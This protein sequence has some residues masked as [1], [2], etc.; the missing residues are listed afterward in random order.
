VKVLKLFSVLLLTLG[1]WSFPALSIAATIEVSGGTAIGAT[2]SYY[3]REPELLKASSG[4]WFLVYARSQTA[5]SPGGNP[6]ILIYDIY[7][8]TSIDNGATW[9]ECD[10]SKRMTISGASFRQASVAEAGGKIWIISTDIMNAPYKIYAQ[11]SSDNGVTWSSPTVIYNPPDA[12]HGAFHVDGVADGNDIWLFFGNW[13]ESLGISYI[14]HHGSTNLWDT[15]PTSTLSPSYQMPRVIK[16]GSTFRMV[17][18]QWDKIYYSTT[19]DPASAIW[20]TVAIPG[21][22]APTG[23]AAS[24]PA[25]FKSTEGAIWVA[26]APWFSTDKQ[27]I[28]YLTSDDNGATWS[29]SMVFTAAE[30]GA[31]FWWDFRPYLSEDGADILFFISSERNYPNVTR[32]VGDILMYRFPKVYSGEAHYESIQ[33]AV[34]DAAAGST[35]NVAEGNYREQVYIDKS[36]NLLGNN[37]PIIEAPAPPLVTYAVPERTGVL[38]EPIIFA[39]GG[40]NDGSGNISG[41]GTINV[42]ISGFKVDG[43]NAGAVNRLTG[44]MVRNCP[45]S[46]ISYN[47]LYELLYNSGLP[48]T[49]GILVYGNS[50]VIVDHNTVNDW[51][52]GGIMVNGDD[53][54]LTDPIATISNNTVVGEGV[55]PQG[56]WAQNGI[57]IGFGAGGSIFG[58]EVSDIAIDDPAWSASGINLYSPA[59]GVTLSSNNVHNCQGSLNAYYCDNLILNDG[60]I[61]DQNDFSFFIGGNNILIEGNTYTANNQ[62]LYMAGVPGVTVKDNNFDGNQYAVIADSA[63]TNPRFLHNIIIGSTGAGAV[64]QPYNGYEPTDVVFHSNAISGNAFG[65]YNSTSSIIDASGNWWGDASGPSVVAPKPVA[66]R[67]QRPKL[68]SLLDGKISTSEPIHAAEQIESAEMIMSASAGAGDLVTTTV[69]YSPWW[70][71]NY[72]NDPHTNL[73]KWYLSDIHQSSLQEAVDAAADGDEIDVLDGLYQMPVNIENRSGLNILGQSHTN[74]I[75]EPIATLGWNVSTYGTSRQTAIRVVNSTGIAFKN[76]TLNFDNIKGNNVSGVLYWSSSGTLAN[77]TISNMNVPDAAGGYYE[78]TCYLRAEAPVF[79]DLNRAQVDILNNQFVKTGRLGIVAHDYVNVLVEG[80]NFDKVDNDFGYGIE[81]GSMATGTIRGNIF[82]KYD[83]WAATD[84]SAAAGIYVENSF[85]RGIGPL[86]KPVLI[87]NNEIY[88]CQY[89]L[90][91]GNQVTGASGAGDVDIVAT[92][93]NNNIH[94]NATTGSETSGGAVLVDEGRDYGSSVTVALTGNKIENI[95]DHGVYIYTTGN[96]DINTIMIDNQVAFNYSGIT[97]KNFGDFSGSVYNLTI[98]HNLFQN[99]FN[100]ENDAITNFWD[101]GISAGNCWSDYNSTHPG[102]PQYNIPGNG[103]SIDRYPNVDCGSYCDCKPGE[104]DGI[105]V[106]NIRDITYLISSLYKGG[107]APTPYAICSGDPN[108]SC[109]V[110]ISDITYLI[111]FLYKSGLPPASCAT[112]WSKCG[113]PIRK[114]TFSDRSLSGPETDAPAPVHTAE[115][116]R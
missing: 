100:A 46:T 24:D 90:Y 88:N 79:G 4:T 77:N 8:S 115:A 58:N 113:L 51:S 9:T 82:H 103:G 104:A 65:L 21:T 70:S 116:F 105:G 75:F 57:Q 35:V 85:T 20:S 80:N 26:C 61:F 98:H 10:A 50:N 89:G 102:Y 7:Y 22:D 106:I 78:L 5:Y 53:G 42:V 43:D 94:D 93:R 92:V 16:D 71:A 29:S 31:D 60:N 2:T 99:Y 6:D 47:D 25:I 40:T 14:K 96:G 45:A 44:I 69:D 63:C 112:W 56:N 101:D 74:T 12:A 107:P 95:E 48:Q 111:N 15:A 86:A 59:S 83:T 76:M 1:I 54:P 37:N 27:R 19:N 62:A 97:V 73:W 38:F 114:M 17:T 87:E 41:S 67:L 81:L 72:Y 64:I 23:G 49:F 32:G 52:R 55:L 28:E 84:H 33:T 30:Y 39:Y 36:L 13:S 110:N 66:G 68:A 108:A 18:T 3:E 34:N 109:N 11:F 91:V